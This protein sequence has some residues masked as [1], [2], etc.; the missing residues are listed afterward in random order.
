MNRK[1]QLDAKAYLYLIQQLKVKI[2]RACINIRHHT[3]NQL[4]YHQN[5]L[6]KTNQSRLY[7]EL[8]GDNNSINESP[9]PEEA[10]TFWKD[11]WATPTG[12]SRN[13]EWLREVKNKLKNLERQY[14]IS[15]YLENLK[16]GIKWMAS[17][18]D[19]GF[20][21]FINKTS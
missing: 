19:P 9:D 6:F 13:T 18:K 8:N 11:I 17:Q 20:L 4:Q 2:S 3:K 1:C 21:I 14:K 10:T 5:K 15:N 16:Q 7:S 12:H